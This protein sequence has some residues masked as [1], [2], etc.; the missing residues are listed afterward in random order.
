MKVGSIISL[1]LVAFLGV[2]GLSAFF[3]SWYT[4][5]ET[6]RVV[7]LTNGS[8]T[9]VQ[10][11]GLHF[12]VPFL[13]SIH[14]YPVTIQTTGNMDAQQG[15]NTYT[16]DNQEVDAWIQV[17]YKITPDN[18]EFVYKNV[19]DVDG[20]VYALT[21]DRFKR[22]MGKYNTSEV[23]AKRGAIAN[24]IRDILEQTAKQT[25]GVEIVDFQ[26]QNLEFNQAFRDAVTAASVAKQQVVK[27]EQELA[28]AKVV[29]EQ[30]KTQAEGQANAVKAKAD[31]DAYA[32]L[33]QATAEA[34]SIQLEG[35]AKAKAIN[36]Q[37]VALAGA[38]TQ[39]IEYTKALNWKGELPQWVGA[40]PM[41][42]MQVTPPTGQ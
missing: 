22:E 38:G 24:D 5:A 8:F 37:A 11:P 6:E 10:G 39:L 40:G 34:K 2:L 36:A 3:G 32:R 42:F 23:A 26:I 27:A 9:S 21:R 35:E 4:V 1:A 20:K 15:L 25:L 14:S 7:L 41:P 16:V 28:Q 13:Q 29:A 33:A 19:P 17:F 18:V 30:N 31:G 12:K